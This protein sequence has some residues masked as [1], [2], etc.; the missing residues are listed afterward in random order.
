MRIHITVTI[1]GAKAPFKTITHDWPSEGAEFVA[2]KDNDGQTD[3]EGPFDRDDP[4]GPVLK[5]RE[6]N[7]EAQALQ[8]EIELAERRAGWDKTP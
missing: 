4:I 6:L 5:L 1:D 8:D 2:T 3:L 7:N